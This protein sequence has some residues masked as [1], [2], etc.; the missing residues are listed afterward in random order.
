MKRDYKL[1]RIFGADSDQTW[2]PVSKQVSGRKGL[3]LHLSM[4]HHVNLSTLSQPD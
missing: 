1:R 4:S 3:H 2:V